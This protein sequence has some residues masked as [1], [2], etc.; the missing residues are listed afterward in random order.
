MGRLYVFGSVDLAASAVLVAM[1]CA[2]AV[3]PAYAQTPT[4]E[5][6]LKQT[7]HAVS[8]TEYEQAARSFPELCHAWQRKLDEDAR[9]QKN[10]LQW[11]DREG[12]KTATYSSYGPIQSCT[13]KLRD[14]VPLGRITYEE[15]EYYIAGRTVEEARNAQP[16]T[17]GS[18]NTIVILRWE[19]GRWNDK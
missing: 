5:D 7:S 11:Q 19:N 10:L 14:G 3:G 13:C 18:T 1:A 4:A 2:A 15:I 12:W 9:N 8:S 17:V 6:A 16:I